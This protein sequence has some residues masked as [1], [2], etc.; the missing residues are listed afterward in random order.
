[1]AVSVFERSGG[2]STVRKIVSS[3]YDKVLESEA[4]CKYFEGAEMRHLIDHQTKFIASMMGGPAAYS[5]EVIERVHQPLNITKPDFHEMTD[6]LRET[7][8]DFELD[9]ADVDHVV[10]EILRREGLVVGRRG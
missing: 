8:E 9:D 7:L 2:F 3:F 4:L 10:H 1:M 6:I 5:D